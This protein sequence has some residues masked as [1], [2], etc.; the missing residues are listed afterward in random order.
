MSTRRGVTSVKRT[1]DTRSGR[2]LVVGRDAIE[3]LTDEERE[4]EATIA[5]YEPRRRGRRF[6]AVLRE[7]ARRRGVVAT[8]QPS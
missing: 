8:T 5:A 2:P 3:L 7:L 1:H 6:D 4:V